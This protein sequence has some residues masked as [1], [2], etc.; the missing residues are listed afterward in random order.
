MENP[1]DGVIPDFSI[2]G[3]EVTELWQKLLGGIWALAIVASIVFLIMGLIKVG[4]NGHAYVINAQGRL[5]AHPDIS[6]V[7]RNTDMTGLVQVQA[8]RAKAALA[9]A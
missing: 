2:F 5:V 8:A 7:L 6:L 9:M 1:L 3:A 4:Q